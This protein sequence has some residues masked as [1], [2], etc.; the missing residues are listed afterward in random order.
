M[1]I[2]WILSLS[3]LSFGSCEKLDGTAA[4][5]TETVEL[6]RPISDE[7]RLKIITEWQSF[8]KQSGESLL[9]A[10]EKIN[11]LASG[12]A[13]NEEAEKA[14]LDH[15]LNALQSRL[16]KL[17]IKLLRRGIR[18]KY[19]INHYTIKDTIENHSFRIAF[20]AKLKVLQT[21]LD[22]ALTDR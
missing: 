20:S 1:K 19:H 13:L 6:D 21:D 16:E 17:K 4:A 3:L 15:R 2:I 7:E 22:A 18:F 14:V 8:R 10:Q 11:R 5:S 9:L 12:V